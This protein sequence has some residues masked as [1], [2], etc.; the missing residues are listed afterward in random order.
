MQR[1]KNGPTC[2]CGIV[3]GLYVTIHIH[4]YYSYKIRLGLAAKYGLNGVQGNLTAMKDCFV[5]KV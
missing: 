2:N 5:Q 4:F 1:R 3:E